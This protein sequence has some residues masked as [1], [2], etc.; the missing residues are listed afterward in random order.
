MVERGLLTDG[1]FDVAFT[2]FKKFVALVRFTGAELGVASDVVDAMWHEFIL[3]TR[4]YVD[5]CEEFLG[6]YLH[7]RPCGPGMAAS[8][9]DGELVM[10]FVTA[11]KG[12]FGELPDVWR[13]AELRC[14]NPAPAK[15][16]AF[17]VSHP[18][19]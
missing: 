8:A 16:S 9:A 2:E 12:V 4:E 3:F 11:Y 10:A 6:S 7:H 19:V 17:R 13:S 1:D 5:F 14:S 18:I 15:C